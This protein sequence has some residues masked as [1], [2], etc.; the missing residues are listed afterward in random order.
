MTL[1]AVL[2]ACAGSADLRVDDSHG[3][4]R[5]PRGQ[6][7]RGPKACIAAADNCDVDRPLTRERRRGRRIAFVA[8]RLVEP[9]RS[10]GRLRRY[11]I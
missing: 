1:A 10:F 4:I 8:E 5:P 3:K 9:P 2:A 6:R 7:E 11:R